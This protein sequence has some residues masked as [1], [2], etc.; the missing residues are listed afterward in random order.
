MGAHHFAKGM[1]LSYNGAIIVAY[2][3]PTESTE[4]RRQSNFA[5]GLKPDGIQLP[6][7]LERGCL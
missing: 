4:G 1:T 5:S 7:N 3:S 6:L 2:Q